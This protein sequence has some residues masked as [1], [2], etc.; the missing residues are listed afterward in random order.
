MSK[1]AKKLFKTCSKTYLVLNHQRNVNGMCF[2][3]VDHNV[4]QMARL[5]TGQSC[6]SLID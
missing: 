3:Q 5:T 2:S 1:V 6:T 4:F